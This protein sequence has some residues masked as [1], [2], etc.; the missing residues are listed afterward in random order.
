[1]ISLQQL[2]ALRTAPRLPDTATLKTF[3]ILY[4]H[5]DYPFPLIQPIR[6][7][8]VNSIV[9]PTFA[10]GLQT[11][12][13]GSPYLPET[14]KVSLGAFLTVDNAGPMCDYMSVTLLDG[15]PFFR[16]PCTN[17]AMC[18]RTVNTPFHIVHGFA[19]A[20][21]GYGNLRDAVAADT[22]TLWNWL[23]SKTCTHAITAAQNYNPV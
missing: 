12:L 23:R 13:K 3:T 22:W 11:I 1:M 20:L 9:G 16:E 6:V 10:I 7:P 21:D 15:P 17:M 14:A 18:S 2:E 5:P 4:I 8:L 19:Y